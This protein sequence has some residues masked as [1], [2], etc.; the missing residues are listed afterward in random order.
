MFKKS[1]LPA[2]FATIFLVQGC[3][4]DKAEEANSMIAAN[5][6]VLTALDNKQYTVKKQASDFVLE[7][8]KGKVVIFDIFATWCP[9]CRAA[10]THLSSLQAKYKDDLIVI[11]VS[12]EDDITNAKL[13]E[14]RKEYDANYTL[15]NSSQ[16]RLLA[17]EIVK[18]LDLGERYPIPI[19]TLYKD[20]K[21]INHYIGSIEEE[22][23]ESDIKKALGK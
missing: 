11:G 22:F 3:S 13:Q 4:S 20:G 10:A 7:N 18:E 2:L 9:P 16:N 6:Y 21:Y 15:V 17:D 14:F 5:E 19:M 23:I 1:L 8:A 12:I